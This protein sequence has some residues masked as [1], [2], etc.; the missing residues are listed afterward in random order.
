MKVIS[1]PLFYEGL[2]QDFAGTYREV[3]QRQSDGRLGMVMSGIG[4]TTRRTTFGYVEAAPH[5]MH[6]RH[7]DAIPTDA[8]S[9]KRYSVDAHPFGVRVQWSRWDREDDQTQSIVDQAKMAGESAAMS[10]ERIFR[11]L[12]TGNTNFLPQTVTA[13]DG[14]NFFAATAGGAARFGVSGGNIVSGS[15]VATVS[16]VLT[17][18]YSSI[19][20]F[21]TMQDGKG[22]RLHP[23]SRIDQGVLIIH[24]AADLKVFEEAF[25]QQRQ[26]S[27][28]GSNTAASTPSNVVIDSSRNVE[29]WAMSELA[30]GDWYV[31]LKGSPIKPTFV[32]ERSP[33]EVEQ[34]FVGDRP[35][36]MTNTT[37]IEY[38]QWT[39]RLGGG[40]NL[41]YGALQVNN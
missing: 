25:M 10:N 16:Q 18:Y 24:S 26:S 35:G 12:L 28:H 32:V 38:I 5:M 21:L 13:P 4:T 30:T 19:V 33:I 1:T 9:S 22:Q 39:Q 11:D 8:M 37:A 2:R 27:V 34:S 17:D 36:D 3:Q 6:W 15:G 31:F 23:S 29:L 20:R 40:I 7:G 41:P 14:A